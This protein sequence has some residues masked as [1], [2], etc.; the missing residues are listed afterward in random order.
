MFFINDHIARSQCYDP[1]SNR[2]SSA[3]WKNKLLRSIRTPLVVRNRI[4]L[5]VKSTALD[6]WTFNVESNSLTCL[7]NWIKI[8]NFCA[9]TVDNY[10][11]VIGGT[12]RHGMLME[13]AR[14]D[15]EQNEWKKNS[16]FE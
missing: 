5:L 1:D 14:F 8:V 3:P 2:W 12:K 7:R 16:A 11:Y 9:V 10:I 15:T 4:C 6:L 13:C